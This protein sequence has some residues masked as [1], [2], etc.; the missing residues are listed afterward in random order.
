[1]AR[2]N[3]L[4]DTMYTSMDHDHDD[5]DDVLLD[6][7]VGVFPAEDELL[8]DNFDFAMDDDVI[9]DLES[10]LMAVEHD[11]F[12]DPLLRT[13]L[14]MWFMG[15]TSVHDHLLEDASF[16]CG[17]VYGIDIDHDHED[18]QTELNRAIGQS[19]SESSKAFG[20]VSAAKSAVEVLEKFKYEKNNESEQMTC[21]ICVEELMNGSHL[22]CMPC[23]HAFHSDCLSQWLNENH[24][25]R[26]QDFILREA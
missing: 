10:L 23:S 12:P 25:R 19:F 20:S 9:E 5:L 16:D 2:N 26:S 15:T 17:S 8:D 24:Q 21:V 14:A 11:Y 4:Y 18:D 3:L 7:N 22:T 1:M 13:D 6:D